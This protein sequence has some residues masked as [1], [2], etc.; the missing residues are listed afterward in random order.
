MSYSVC[1]EDSV[2]IGV[3]SLRQKEVWMKVCSFEAALMI[4]FCENV[5]LQ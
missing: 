5:G 2:L 1:Q 4:I 3:I